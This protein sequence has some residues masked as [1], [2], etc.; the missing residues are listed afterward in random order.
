[1]SLSFGRVCALDWETPVRVV[2][3][4]VD[5]NVKCVINNISL[6]SRTPSRAGICLRVYMGKGYLKLRAGVIKCGDLVG[7]PNP[8]NKLMISQNAYAEYFYNKPV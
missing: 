7:T 5:L 8:G 1:M 4:S 2:F 6:P 3:C